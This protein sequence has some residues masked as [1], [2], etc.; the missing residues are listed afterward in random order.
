MRRLAAALGP[1]LE[2]LRSNALRTAL[3]T[4]GLTMGVA[5]LISVMTVIQGANQFVAD[6]I[7][8]LGSDV[9]RVSKRSFDITD[10]E[11]YYLSQRNPDI[12][13]ADARA[14]AEGCE[15][16]KTVGISASEQTRVRFRSR[17]ISDVTFEGASA[18]MAEIS[19]RDLARGRWFTEGEDR[20]AAEVCL[21]GSEV[22]DELFPGI[23]PLGREVRV[24]ERPLRVIGVFA[25]VGA[26][27]G[28]SQD[29]FLTAPLSRFRQMRGLR[30]SLTLEIAAGEGAQFQR[31]QDQTRAI[32]RARRGLTP[33]DRENFY[34]GAAENYIAL[35]E[36]ISQS[37]QAVFIGVSSVAALVGG[38]VIM[39]IMLVSVTQR[40]REIGIRRACGARRGDILAQ[41]LAESFAQ[42]ALGGVLGALLGVGVAV[43]LRAAGAFPAE[44]RWWAAAVGIGYAAAIGL[45][46]GIYPAARAASL[47]PT[48]ALR[49]ER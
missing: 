8:N 9:F 47:E 32:L 14:V 44:V 28:R 40:T 35:W 41:F 31:A 4:L 27:L 29:R 16:C 23:D 24:G 2:S 45:F 1:A 15:D 34:L 48:E 5:A 37:F 7:A 25:P 20:H 26:V 21:I 39:N 36:D 10:L 19:N 46:F 3:T 17:E 49:A 12:T 42:C 38:I 13:L 33:T 18:S 43:A 11:E 6:K 22:A 30:L